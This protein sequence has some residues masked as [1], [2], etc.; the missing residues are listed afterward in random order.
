MH[1]LIFATLGGPG[2]IEIQAISLA[3]FWC[4]TRKKAHLPTV[5]EIEP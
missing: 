5:L 1:Q 4:K 2:N 3:S